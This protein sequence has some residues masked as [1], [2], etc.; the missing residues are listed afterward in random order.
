[1]TNKT[2]RI[3]IA[4]I[5]LLFGFILTAGSPENDASH[6]PAGIGSP[7][8]LPMQTYPNDYGD[9]PASLRFCTSY[10]NHLSVHGNT[11]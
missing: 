3:I 11:G 9:A 10:Y 4:L 7:V 2:S 6:F 1:M 5:S 8:A